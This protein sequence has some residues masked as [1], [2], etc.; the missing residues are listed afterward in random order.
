M[1]N[2][3][4][5]TFLFTSSILFSQTIEVEIKS[6]IQCEMCSE[7]ITDA[8]S[9]LKGVKSIKINLEDQLIKVKYNSKKMNVEKIEESITKIGYDANNR[10]ANQEVYQNL[11]YCCQKPE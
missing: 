7:N 5:I 8:L 3:L 1:K 11:P 2:L 6:S 10:K 9:L 4:L